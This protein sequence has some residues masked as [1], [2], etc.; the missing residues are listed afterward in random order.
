MFIPGHPV[1]NK[2]KGRG[3]FLKG[4][5]FGYIKLGLF[6]YESLQDIIIYI[7]PEV[8]ILCL[9]MVNSI[10][11]RMLGFRNQSE[12]DIED[13]INGIHR[14]IERGNIDK[15]QEQLKLDCYMNLGH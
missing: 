1:H 9:L 13:I 5:I 2:H 6:S 10:Y 11:L 12:H 15:V 3:G 4:E 14:T 8:C 7:L